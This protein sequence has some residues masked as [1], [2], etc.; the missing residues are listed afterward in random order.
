V[1]ALSLPF[2][3]VGRGDPDIAVEG[4]FAIVEFMAG[5]LLKQREFARRGAYA[6]SGLTIVQESIFSYMHRLVVRS[7]IHDDNPISPDGFDL[8]GYCDEGHF[9]LL[10]VF[11]DR[12]A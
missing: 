12:L 4:E 1:R 6:R 3:N 11:W 9:D 5:N 2:G 10:G 7:G 8:S